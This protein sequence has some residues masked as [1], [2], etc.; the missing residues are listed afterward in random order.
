M[1]YAGLTYSDWRKD[2]A[3]CKFDTSDNLNSKDNMGIPSISLRI[4][5]INPRESQ[6]LCTCKNE[7]LYSFASLD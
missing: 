2:Y 5:F 4:L 7:D 1:P 6:P 3:D